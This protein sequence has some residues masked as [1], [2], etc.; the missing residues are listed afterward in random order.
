MS[1]K[2]GREGRGGKMSRKAG[3]MEEGMNE[4]KERRMKGRKD[5]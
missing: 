4:R 5:G 2:V 1:K 3:R